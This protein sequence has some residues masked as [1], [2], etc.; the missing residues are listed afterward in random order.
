VGGTLHD[1][2]GRVV[3]VLEVF[4]QPHGREVAPPQLLYQH[5]S[6]DQHFPHV[7]GVVPSYF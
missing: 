7:A 6:V 2:D 1:L 4:G 5:V 3:V